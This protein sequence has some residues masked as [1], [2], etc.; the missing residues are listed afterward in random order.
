MGSSCTSLNQGKKQKKNKTDSKSISRVPGPKPNSSVPLNLAIISQGSNQN[1]NSIKSSASSSISQPVVRMVDPYSVPLPISHSINQVKDPAIRE[2]SSL[3]TSSLVANPNQIQL[4]ENHYLNRLTKFQISILESKFKQHQ[5][6]PLGLDLP[7][8]KSIM[9]YISHL[10]ANIIENA[11]NEFC[12]PQTRHITWLDFCKA[13]SKF[14]LGSTEEKCK[15][16]Y[17]IFE[18]KKQKTLTKAEINQ[19]TTYIQ[20]TSN[21]FDFNSSLSTSSIYSLLSTSDTLSYDLFRNWAFDN[22][23]LHKALQPFEVVPSAATEKEYFRS[24]INKFK[25]TG[26]EEGEF[27]YLISCNWLE[28][29]KAFVKYDVDLNGE[30]SPR[31]SYKLGS[32]PVAIQNFPLLDPKF[33]GKLKDG[34]RENE[35]FV[36]VNR[37]IWKDLYKWY[38]GG[39]EIRRQAI[40]LGD[41]VIVEIYLQHFQINLDLVGVKQ[42][43]DVFVSLNDK[44][45][46]LL[47]RFYQNSEELKTLKFFL[48]VGSKYQHFELSTVVKTLPL[49]EVNYGRVKCLNQVEDGKIATF[50]HDLCEG[51]TI[52]YKNKGYWMLGAV[53]K[54]T[55]QNIVIKTNWNKRI[56]AVSHNNLRKLRKPKMTVVKDKLINSAVGLVNLGNTC[57]LNSILQSLFHTPLFKDFFSS[58]NFRIALQ[59]SPYQ[60]L[61]LKLF[62]L[63]IEYKTTHKSRIRPINFYKELLKKTIEFEAGKEND[64]HELLLVLLSMIH[65]G[66]VPG[67]LNMQMTLRL[68]DLNEIDEKK[69]SKKQ[70]KEYREGQ[71]SI[72]SAIFAGQTRN[73]FTCNYCG[74]KKVIFEIFNDLSVPIPKPKTVFMGYVKFVPRKTENIEKIAIL[75][76]PN[77][78]FEKFLQIIEE[79]TQLK[80]RNLVFAYNRHSICLSLFQPLELSEL[81]KKKDHELCAF[82][83]LTY[84]EEVEKVS[85][86]FF[87]ERNPANWREQLKKMQLVDVKVEDKWEIAHI[88]DINSTKVKLRTH[89]NPHATLT[90]DKTSQDLQAFASQVQVS[91]RVLHIP[92]NHIKVRKITPF[93]QPQVLSIGSWFTWHEVLIELRSI[94]YIFSKTIKSPEN[95]RFFLYNSKKESCGICKGNCVGCEILDNFAIVSCLEDIVQDLFI[96]VFWDD[97]SCYSYIEPKVHSKLEQFHLHECFDKFSEKETIDLKCDSCEEKSQTCQIELWRLPDILVVHLKR[98]YNERNYLNKIDSLIKFPIKNLNMSTLMLN[99]KKNSGLCIK[100]SENNFLYDL[101][102]VVNHNGSI[103]S[104]HY[105][106]YCL[107][108][109]EKWLFFDDDKT[110]LL[111]KDIEEEIVSNK[112]YIL[113]YKR[114]RFRPSNILHSRDI[115]NRV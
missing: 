76:S 51:E 96:R 53:E 1:I 10:P 105:T 111:N 43:A 86:Y 66:L 101:F 41:K 12:D 99:S 65:E 16:L 74:T 24:E 93:G 3:V 89:S 115:L 47:T 79:K 109:D 4:N 49:A 35:D 113:F 73:C 38:E 68:K 54:V 94:V 42:V 69:E 15:F 91:R 19:L 29:W 64:C 108:E 77:D 37:K 57:F 34:L 58:E 87:T 9:P 82:E 36:V 107:N 13:V 6:S 2:P 62:E 48:K 45:S 98:F 85:K 30:K 23:D 22:L 46:E 78:P 95:T 88:S 70:W 56:V 27:Y 14:V 26:L 40:R 61:I 75:L 25:K 90:L 72:I 8:F 33:E 83:V 17:T 59:E 71:G 28:T 20:S 104:G 97:S 100:N 80:S 106:T 7:S 39:P 18:N 32:R 50:Q 55:D 92:V 84:L 110:F 52:E 11:F 67:E 60:S 102:A 21:S 44:V 63:L 81:F 103:S 114:Q 5:S 112:A 31:I